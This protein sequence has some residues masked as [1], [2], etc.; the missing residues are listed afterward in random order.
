M[1]PC[2]IDEII[3]KLYNYEIYIASEL[4]QEAMGVVSYIIM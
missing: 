1:L 3:S 4:V 2:K